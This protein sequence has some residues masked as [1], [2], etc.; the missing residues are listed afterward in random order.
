MAGGDFAVYKYKHGQRMTPSRAHLGWA[1]GFFGAGVLTLFFVFPLALVLIAV[2]AWQ[3]WGRRA[4][5]GLM[6]GPRYLICGNTILY[7]RNLRRVASSAR[8]VLE[9]YG[10][11]GAPLRIEQGRFPTDARKTDKIERNTR[12]K[13]DKASALI[14]ERARAQVPEVEVVGSIAPRVAKKAGT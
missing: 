11:T 13:F 4:E 10:S 12:A 3:V 6:I 5:N 1:L 14:V 8:G 2:G 9:L 7:Y